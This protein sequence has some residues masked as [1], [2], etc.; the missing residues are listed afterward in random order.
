MTKK[1]EI[2]NSRIQWIDM[3]KGY[4]IVLVLLGH[5]HVNEMMVWIYSFHMPLFFFLSGYLFSVKS[6]FREFAAGKVRKLLVPYLA[7][8][9]PAI[10]SE[11]YFH[12]QLSWSN[13]AGCI[14]LVITQQRHAIVWFLGCIIVLH[15]LFYPIV[16]YCRNPIW[17]ILI[18]L[19]MG[20]TG[21]I[22]WRNGITNL[23][24][25]CDVALVV[26]PFFMAA[27]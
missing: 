4:G 17:G 16:R 21:V 12:S 14:P 19:L 13:L 2:N 10:V 24:W 5:L 26:A 11:L 22:L 9:I 6:S 20:L 7:L 3:A 27:I 1:S 8:Y 23:Y 15:F 18:T 25:N